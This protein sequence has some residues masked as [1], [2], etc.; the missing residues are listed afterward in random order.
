V[1]DV[2]VRYWAGARQVAGRDDE[3]CVGSSVQDVVRQLAD[4]SPALAEVLRRSSLLLDGQIVHQDDLL[5][6]D[7]L[8]DG[9]T[10]EVLPPF[11]GG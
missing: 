6:D 8:R 5:R 10:L 4:R 1:A 7:A 2:L 9:Q 3:R 11:A